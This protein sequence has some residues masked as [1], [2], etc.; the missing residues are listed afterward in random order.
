MPVSAPCSFVKHVCVREECCSAFAGTPVRC[1]GRC[2]TCPCVA[3]GF[4]HLHLGL[5]DG[6][7]TGPRTFVVALP[8]KRSGCCCL[9]S[10]R[11]ASSGVR[12]EETKQNQKVLLRAYHIAVYRFHSFYMCSFITCC[13]P[14]LY[15]T[16]TPPP[17][18]HLLCCHCCI[19]CLV[20][21][22]TKIICM[23]CLFARA[24]LQ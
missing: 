16:L 19:L 6:S 5:P 8:W 18:L 20:C 1:A 23:L 22:K 9:P 10:T 2:Q 12:L 17:P 3:Q 14:P 21:S 13:P 15:C 4:L 11:M 24:D 7:A